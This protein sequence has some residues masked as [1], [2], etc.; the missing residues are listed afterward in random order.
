M[1]I[2]LIDGPDFLRTQ[3]NCRGKVLI[4]SVKDFPDYESC[5]NKCKETDGCRYFGVWDSIDLVNNLCRGW[6]SCDKCN[7]AVYHNQVY[8]L[9]SGK[10]GQFPVS[11]HDKVVLKDLILVLISIHS[12]FQF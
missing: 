5:R 2:H 11:G 6:D 1:N 4:E 7:T 12:N 9:E 3:C 8:E 10:D